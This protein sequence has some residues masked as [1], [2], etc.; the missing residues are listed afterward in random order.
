MTGSP[1]VVLDACVL[2]N[3]W[4][5]DTLLRLAEPPPLFESKWSEQIIRE[6]T[7]TLETNRTTARSERDRAASG[8]VIAAELAADS[9]AGESAFLGQP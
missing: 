7:S 3:F 8:S 2:A 4:L 9:F 1:L 6:T 5:C